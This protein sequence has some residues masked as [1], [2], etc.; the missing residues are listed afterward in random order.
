MWNLIEANKT[1]SN[2]AK[3][4]IVLSRSQHIKNIWQT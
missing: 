3:V 2:H 1:I 4:V